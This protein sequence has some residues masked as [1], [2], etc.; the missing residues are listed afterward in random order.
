MGRKR[1]RGGGPTKLFLDKRLE[2]TNQHC[3]ESALFA[4]VEKADFRASK[5]IL[6]GHAAVRCFREKFNASPQAGRCRLRPHNYQD[7]RMLTSA[8]VYW[9]SHKGKLYALVK[10]RRGDGRIYIDKT[11]SSLQIIFIK[12]FEEIASKRAEHRWGLLKPL[13]G[14][15]DKDDYG[16]DTLDSLGSS[17]TAIYTLGKDAAIIKQYGEDPYYVMRGKVYRLPDWLGPKGALWN[18]IDGAKRLKKAKD[19]LVERGSIPADPLAD[20]VDILGEIDQDKEKA[21]KS[22]R[23][24]MNLHN[25]T[26]DDLVEKPSEKISENS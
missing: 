3:I 12:E 10:V 1:N 23:H 25:L 26:I 8:V 5:G 16:D 4:M 19:Y 15:K 24:L 7:L 22:I 17:V 18:S 14:K 20:I 11:S 2:D 13:Y 9:A 21:I 6:D